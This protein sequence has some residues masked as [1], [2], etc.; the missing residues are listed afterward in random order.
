MGP[1]IQS[2]VDDQSCGDLAAFPGQYIEGAAGR[3]RVHHFEAYAIA[4]EFRA[5]LRRRE[6]LGLARAEQHHFQFQPRQAVEVGDGKLR[7]GGSPPGF[8]NTLGCQDQV[9]TVFLF[10][11]GYRLR[12]KPIYKI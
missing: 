2:W 10:C 3:C 5:Q 12:R 9:M 11:H 4:P 6:Y 1:A 7:Y 8:E